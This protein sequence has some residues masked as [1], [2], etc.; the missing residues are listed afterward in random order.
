MRKYLYMFF[1]I[2]LFSLLAC[3]N[4]EEGEATSGEL[5]YEP[6]AYTEI[7]DG[8]NG[9]VEVE[10]TFTEDRIEAVDI[11][12][13][14][15][16]PDISDKP[17]NEFPNLIVENQ[18]LAMDAV[19]GATYI[20]EA[21]LTAV[22]GAVNQAGG[23]VEALKNV[24]ITTEQ[25]D[26]VVPIATDVLVIGSGAA[27]MA[28]SLRA[29]ELGADVVLLEKMPFIGGAIS[30][31]GG[32]QVVMG[33]EL[34]AEA[35]VTN[36]S[37]ESLIQDLLENGAHMNDEETLTLF[38]EN[39]GETT[40]WLNQYVGIKYDM[41]DGLHVLAEY[42]HDRELAYVNGG[43]GFTETA[44]QAMENS[45]IELYTS[46]TANELVVESGRVVG[47]IAQ[48]DSGRTY[49]I[50]A[51]SVILATG[52]YG[53]ND[54]L[55]TDELKNILYY[56]IESAT[57]DGILMAQ[58]AV[59]ADT[60]LMKYGKQY[61]NG[62]EVSEGIAKSTIGGNITAFNE[63]SAILIND[64]GE[65][66]VNE[67]ASNRDILKVQLA[68]ESQMFYLLLDEE[69]FEMWTPGLAHA[70]ISESDIDGWLENNGSETPYF[71]HGDSL[72]DVAEIAD[73]NVDVLSA[74]VEQY[75]HAV[76]AGYDETFN[77]P[78]AFMNKEVEGNHF[79]LI[80]Q[81]PR[82]AT[83]MGGLVLNGDLQVMNT[84]QD[85]IEGLYA[86][87]E[88]EGG[89]MG[90]DSPSGA[91]NAWALTSGKIAAEKAFETIE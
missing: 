4:Q 82:F 18:S 16:S 77:R 49:E 89:V 50:T 59:A 91:N 11:V 66:V 47:A 33:S 63:G 56:G 70:G 8:H 88:I 44:E 9:D 32:N 85:P 31:S 19:S 60:Q 87:G 55:L 46:T 17:L 36:D 22:E 5:L 72:E 2:L 26:E 45:D 10:V 23:D 27:G 30:V 62:V 75:N 73:I 34:Q 40:N 3:S 20:S 80:E 14:N 57:G 29:D 90:D 78:D 39:V 69:T 84:D 25:V 52:G 64:A 71:I 12:S 83:T 61:P 15:E 48:E 68:E 79:Y 43:S 54:A 28:A 38:A 35:G 41:E 42:E 76:Q 13:H 51:E 67:K 6:G 58:E 24:P 81:K 7:V 53:N 37:A 86:A 65:R 1:F 21:I 74:T